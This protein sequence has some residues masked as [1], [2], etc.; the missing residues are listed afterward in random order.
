MLSYKWIYKP[1]INVDES[2][3]CFSDTCKYLWKILETASFS[4]LPAAVRCVITLM[5][6]VIQY[7]FLYFQQITLSLLCFQ[8][9]EIS[10]WKVQYLWLIL[11]CNTLCRQ[12]LFF[13]HETQKKFSMSRAGTEIDIY[14][15]EFLKCF[16]FFPLFFSPSNLVVF[17]KN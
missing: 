15:V 13:Y 1:I 6:R 11:G 14:S 12:V 16:F 10:P 8:L 17:C 2:S 3:V 4:E 7:R 5:F 9:G